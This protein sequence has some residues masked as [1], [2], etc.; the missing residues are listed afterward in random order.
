MPHQ[1]SRP[2]QKTDQGPR[3]LGL[4]RLSSNGKATLVPIAIRIDGRFY[5]AASYKANP[6]PMA[7][8]SGTVYEGERSGTSVGL[9]TV[10]GA[11]HSNAVNAV[12]PWL[13][14]GMWL[15]AGTDVPQT[16]MKAESVP[17]GIETS[18]QPPRLS[19][20]QKKA[21]ETPAGG[22]PSPSSA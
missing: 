21:Q 17:R 9:F 12:T 13:G 7:L 16:A 8:E 20:N 1:P 10:N 6:V 19:K 5:D 22:T 14:T 2:P 3:A 11:L 15:P 18:D 4:V